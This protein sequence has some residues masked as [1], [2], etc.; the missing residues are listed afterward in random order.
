MYSSGKTKN[1]VL[2]LALNLRGHPSGVSSERH[3]LQVIKNGDDS[4]ESKNQGNSIRVIGVASCA[5]VYLYCCQQS[6]RLAWK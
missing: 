1:T 3:T 6:V 4:K 2:C 5:D